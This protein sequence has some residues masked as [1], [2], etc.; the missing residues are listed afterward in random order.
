MSESRQ[1]HLDAIGIGDQR[2]SGSLTQ[3]QGVVFASAAFSMDINDLVVRL[4]TDASA[5]FTVTLPSVKE[6]MG[7]TYSLALV[8]DGRTDA[9]IEDKVGD[10]GY[11]DAVFDT[12]NDYVLLYSDGYKWHEILSEKA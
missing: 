7:R 4:T 2:A 5:G 1:T 10:A 3:N 8:T 6:A 11:T 9:T 12:A